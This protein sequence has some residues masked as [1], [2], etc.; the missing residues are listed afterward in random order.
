MNARRSL[1]RRLPRLLAVGL[2]THIVYLSRSPLEILV[3]LIE[4]LIFATIAVYLF[5]AGDRPGELLSAA[6]GAGLMGIW[7]SVLFG[8]GAAIQ[9]QRW[10]GVLEP[11]AAAPVPLVLVFLPITLASAAVGAYALLA[12]L[13]WGV[14]LFGVPLDFA[15]P[16]AF[17]AAVPATV[18]SLGMVGLLLAASFVLLPNANALAN[19]LSY[20]VWM[21]SGMLVPVDVLPAWSAPLSAALPSKWGADA[22]RAAVTGGDAWPPI[23]ICLAV[24]LCYLVLG[25]LMMTWVERRARDAAT[26]ALA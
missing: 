16:L 13:I 11:L 4:P 2:R 17:V 24:G 7:A 20:P 10:M 14:L 26:L 12:T 18:L 23:L 22:L 1:P 25:A 15:D 6:V 8:S 19:S 3:A 9:N 21:M 5:R